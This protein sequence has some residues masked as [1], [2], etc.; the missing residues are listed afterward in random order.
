MKNLSKQIVILAFVLLS[1]SC[2]FAKPSKIEYLMPTGFTG[3]VIVLYN[4]PD[5][6]APEVTADGT[7]RYR[8][9]FSQLKN[10]S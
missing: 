5:G 6:T 8:I 7:V 10:L 2:T 9:F 3:G 4:Q 1:A